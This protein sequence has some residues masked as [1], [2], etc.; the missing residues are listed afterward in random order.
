MMR[1]LTTKYRYLFRLL[2]ASDEEN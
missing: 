2:T 1:R